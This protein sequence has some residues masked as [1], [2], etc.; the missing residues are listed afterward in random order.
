MS[1]ESVNAVLS[2]VLTLAGVAI[3]L[4]VAVLLALFFW[5]MGR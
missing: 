4:V 2:L 5:Q 3:A 1:I